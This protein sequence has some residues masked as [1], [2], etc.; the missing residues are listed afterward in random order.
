MLRGTVTLL[1]TH[2][3]HSPLSQHQPEPGSSHL[4]INSGSCS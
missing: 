4:S 2:Q 3:A 1:T